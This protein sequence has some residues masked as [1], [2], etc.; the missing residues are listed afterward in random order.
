MATT[1]VVMMTYIHTSSLN[2]SRNL[3]GGGFSVL[4]ICKRDYVNYMYHSYFEDNYPLEISL[5]SC[6]IKKCTFI[7]KDIPRSK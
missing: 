6:I 1:N 3:N 4:G 2:G 5:Y 7:T